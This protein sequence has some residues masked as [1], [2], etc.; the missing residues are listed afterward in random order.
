MGAFAMRKSLHNIFIAGRF[1]PCLRNFVKSI[2]V[3]EMYHQIAR[4]LPAET[5]QGSRGVLQRSSEC[6]DQILMGRKKLRQ[7]E[8]VA[9]ARDH[10]RHVLVVTCAPALLSTSALSPVAAIDLLRKSLRELTGTSEQTV[11][12]CIVQAAQN[13]LDVMSAK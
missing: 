5:S 1:N 9:K 8:C 2:P 6:S 11:R 7:T 4:N 3:A 13:T 10:P 12:N